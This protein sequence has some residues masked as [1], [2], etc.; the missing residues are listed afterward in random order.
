MKITNGRRVYKLPVPLY[1]SYELLCKSPPYVNIQV[2]QVQQCSHLCV[3]R[4]ELYSYL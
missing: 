2:S 1:H 3:G 4:N